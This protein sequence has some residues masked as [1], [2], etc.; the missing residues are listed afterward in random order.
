MILAETSVA[1]EVYRHHPARVLQIIVA[2]DA[3]V[4]GVTAAELY[5]GARTAAEQAR[6]AATLAAF[7]ALLIPDTVWPAVGRT[8]AALRAKGI[9]IPFP[10]AVLATLAVELDTELWTYDAHFALMQSVLT[11]LR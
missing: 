3:A 9:T 2:H 11:G 7:Q 1:I 6:C 8:I 4:C 10:D 5:A